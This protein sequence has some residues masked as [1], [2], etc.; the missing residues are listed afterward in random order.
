MNRL[1][2]LWAAY[3][4][5][6]LVL[7]AFAGQAD[8]Q[9]RNEREIR[10]TIRSLNTEV[11]NFEYTLM[12][13]LRT[14]SADRQEVDDAATGIGILKDS[15]TEFDRNFLARREN[16][17]DVESIIQAARDVNAFLIAYP[18]N[19]RVD[20]DWQAVR[21]LVDR[22]AASY[23]VVPDWTGRRSNAS[24]I[25]RDD[26]IYTPP[27]DDREP[28]T[29]R[30]D[31]A[32]IPPP[33]NRSGPPVLQGERTG[34]PAPQIVSSA[35][36][37]S[38]LTGT[39]QVDSSRTDKPEQILE[40][41]NLSQAR[42]YELQIR[43]EAPERI[44]LDV[45]GNQISLATTKAD[46]VTFAADGSETTETDSGGRTLRTKAV[47]RGDEIEIAS[48]GGETDYTVTFASENNGQT[49]KVTRRFTVNYLPET[50][51][52]ESYYTKSDNVAKLGVNELLNPPDPG[53]YSSNDPNDRNASNTTPNYGGTPTYRGTPRSGQT[54]GDHIVPSGTIIT[55]VLETMI[56]TKVTQNN[57]RFRATVQ[58][59]NEFRGAVIEGYLSGVG[60][61]GQVSGRSNVTFN[62][63]RITMRDGRSYDFSGYLQGVKDHQG[64]IVRVDT[65]GTA[66]GD[67]QTTETAKRGGIG[68]GIGALIGAIAG[69]AKGAVIGAVIGGGAGAGSVI[70]TGRDDLQLMQGS[71]LT[72]QSTSPGRERGPR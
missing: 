15:V 28:V 13:Q 51:V 24:R 16:A 48:V 36:V 39:Y 64:K 61:S 21:E 19:R 71:T 69:G 72:I 17:A 66:K 35:A 62:F 46:P 52:A 23:G 7:I 43:L 18:Q 58:A 56:D 5:V 49:L 22:L 41:L 70:A 45:R 11:D 53:S 1:R 30:D 54:A 50:L 57:D 63:E 44:A 65:E 68:A 29:R 67:S 37:N 55:A 4:A 3:A 2:T 38:G 42:K 25:Q 26:D 40:G 47:I 59:P 12:Y 14:T 33:P 8:A 31:D 32:Y 34:T 9:R 20:T 60:R 6:G 27:A 10:D